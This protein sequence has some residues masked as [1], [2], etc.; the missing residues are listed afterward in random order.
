MGPENYER[1][2]IPGYAGLAFSVIR[3]QPWYSRIRSRVTR[4][5]CLAYSGFCKAKRF[6]EYLRCEWRR[7][8]RRLGLMKLASVGAMPFPPEVA[9]EAAKTART[10]WHIRRSRDRTTQVSRAFTLP[11]LLQVDGQTLKDRRDHWEGQ[12]IAAEAALARLQEEI[13]ELAFR[14]YGLDGEDR[15]RMEIGF[16]GVGSPRG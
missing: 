7:L 1:H 11:A 5:H 10:A 15:Q 8:R 14:L 13:D 4:T 6:G 9:S 16:G 3:D 12:V 2:F